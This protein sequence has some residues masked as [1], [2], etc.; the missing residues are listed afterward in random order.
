MKKNVLKILIVFA[1]ISVLVL[2]FVACNLKKTDSPKIEIN[3]DGYWVING[4]VTNVK[5]EGKDG[6]NGLNG[7]DGLTPTISINDDGFWVINGV[8]TTVKARGTDGVNGKDG[9]N[10]I[11][12]KDGTNGKDGKDGID[13]KDG[14][15]INKVILDKNA[16]GEPVLIFYEELEDG[17]LIE[18]S[19]I[20]I[21]D[22]SGKDGK[23]GD[24]GETPTIAI[25][26]NGFWVIN[27]E[28][29]SIKAVGSDGKNG[30]NGFDGHDGKDGKNIF[31]LYKEVYGYEG[32][33]EEWLK[34]VLN[35]TLGSAKKHTV[36]F[37][38][39]GFEPSSDMPTSVKVV[40]GRTIDLPE[41]E[42][43][44]FEFL[45]WFV[46]N[47]VND[48]QWLN[49]L[50]VSRDLNLVARWKQKEFEV[51]FETEDG[52][53]LKL[54]KVKYGD[55]ATPPDAPHK[56]GY[57]F[58]SWDGET[59]NITSN[60]TIR[61]VYLKIRYTI[62]YVTNSETVL[63]S[64]SYMFDEIPKAPTKPTKGGFIFLG[65]KLEGAEDDDF[66][67]FNAPLTSDITLVAVWSDTIVISD[68]DGL[69]SIGND[70]S[71]NYSLG[72]NINLNGEEWMPLGEFK[73]SL[74]G[75][76]YKIYNFTMNTS[77]NEMGFFKKNSGVIKDI[78]FSDVSISNANN[79]VSNTAIVTA[80]NNGE[81]SGITLKEST[82]GRSYSIM[83]VSHN[84]IAVGGISGINNGTIKDSSVD[85]FAT[86][87]IDTGTNNNT[88]KSYVCYGSVTGEN[89]G[90]IE[91]VNVKSEITYKG[92]LYSS[93]ANMSLYENIGGAVGENSGNIKQIKTNISLDLAF[94]GDGPA[95]P[96]H[97][98]RV[99]GVVGYNL[100]EITI[101]YSIGKIAIT[102]TGK[103]ISG[104][105]NNCAGIVGAN[106]K[107]IQYCMSSLF[108]ESKSSIDGSFGG[109]VGANNYEGK[110]T[111]CIFDGE[112]INSKGK[113]GGI[114]GFA[115]G[116]LISNCIMRGVI[117][118]SSNS[119]TGGI[120]GFVETR[121]TIMRCVMDG[122]IEMTSS[123]TPQYIT[124]NNANFTKC[125]RTENAT[126][127]VGENTVE[128][129]QSES[130]V[131]KP[132]EEIYEVEFFFETLLFNEDVWGLK[133]DGRGAY[134]KTLLS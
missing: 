100:G 95:S 43:E 28:T 48:G 91:N 7:K 101:S 117:Y 3:S 96:S 21:K 20:N 25:D 106:E 68:V 65:W 71:A 118:Q 58:D 121:S 38:Y 127:V 12:G 119:N 79:G 53:L 69:K 51:R 67:K 70:L 83:N 85:I 92:S 32:T 45:G 63:P 122:T 73:G 109:I 72:R 74:D 39:N 55:N 26:E 54:E 80:V 29:T 14:S 31:D 116:G 64:E 59:E 57:I 37:D 52:E 35:G 8:V 132:C 36:T 15:S 120:A 113:T 123:G 99:G 94:S 24:D 42:R 34:D 103:N 44:G 56:E 97:Y 124:G 41:P 13:G 128:G 16:D 78:V 131:L 60:R 10:G 27:G 129:N 88:Q 104:G 130:A 86:I 108:I 46:G 2:S 61:P 134:L 9:L 98:R 62:T 40:D 84:S 114:V 77:T 115:V 5:A 110:T 112:I 33:L 105:T 126:L 18:R 76:G 81:I 30:T 22:L 87:D 89:Y 82:V 75:K 50:V 93:W 4:E 90:N 6:R 1:I 11:N 102:N 125:Y 66:F 23:N 111:E 133:P 19:R 47:S 107:L 17:T 49:T